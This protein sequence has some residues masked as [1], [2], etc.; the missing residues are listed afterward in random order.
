L[1]SSKKLSDI[2][3]AEFCFIGVVVQLCVRLCLVLA[4]LFA[5]NL[6]L[7]LV[8]FEEFQKSFSSNIIWDI[9]EKI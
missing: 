3:R 7:L 9:D 1:N 5:V 6:S 4:C 2:V 8:G